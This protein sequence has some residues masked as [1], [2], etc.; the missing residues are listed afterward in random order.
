MLRLSLLILAAVLSSGCGTMITQMGGI[1]GHPNGYGIY[2]GVQ[3]DAEG[4][5]WAWSKEKPSDY[6][7]C[8]SMFVT[9]CLCLDMP[10]SAVFDTILIPMVLMEK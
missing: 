3:F 6:T 2:D 8:E 9:F 1:T 10:F 7:V 5:G 4:I